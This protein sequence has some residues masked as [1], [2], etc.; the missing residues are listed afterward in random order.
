MKNIENIDLS[1]IMPIYNEEE[2]LWETAE[3]LA[4]QLD[5][6]VGKERWQYVLVDNGSADSTS[7]ITKRITKYW[8]SSIPIK[9]DRPNIGNAL[10]AG[11]ERA[12]GE[13]AYII[14]VD[15]WDSIFLR[16]SWANRNRYDLIVGSGRADYTL[17]Q[18]SRYRKFLSWG[19][20]SLLRLLCGFEGTDTHGQKLLRLSSMRPVIKDCI[21][22]RGQFDTEFTLRAMRKG[23]WIADVPV[24]HIE[25]RKHRN[26]MIKKIV[27]NIWDIFR[28]SRALKKVPTQAIRFHRWAR[29]DLENVSE[30]NK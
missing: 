22:R 27:Q 29:E 18:R 9:L 25:I 13:W 1:L 14:N 23:L 2:I 28:L 6:I 19:L 30:K 21:M 16:W 8:P 20:N 12:E 5:D 17:Y 11:L 26:W 7:Q 4:V 24:P 15:W 3:Q 10:F